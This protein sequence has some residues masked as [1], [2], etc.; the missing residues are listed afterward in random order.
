VFV[1][2]RELNNSV[3]MTGRCMV[4]TK[5]VWAANIVVIVMT[6]AFVL[7]FLTYGSRAAIAKENLPGP[8]TA[9]GSTTGLAFATFSGNRYT[10]QE[11]GK[12]LVDEAF[13]IGKSGQIVQID[14]PLTL[15]AQ[16][17]PPSCEADQRRQTAVS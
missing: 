9:T 8:L 3:N 2:I 12:D 14:E 15:S 11:V 10:V 1:V 7:A 4:R 16:V 13:S 6:G 17:P 5:I